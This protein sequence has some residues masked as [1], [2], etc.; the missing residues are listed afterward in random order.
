[1]NI[2][3]FS[4]TKVS[5]RVMCSPKIKPTFLIPLVKKLFVEIS[6]KKLETTS[7]TGRHK[8]PYFVGN[9]MKQDR[10]S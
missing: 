5:V 7:S 3:T 1:M 6:K 10:I 8:K 2:S 4:G 9:I